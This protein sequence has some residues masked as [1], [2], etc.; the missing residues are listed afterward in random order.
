MSKLP[1]VSG[2]KC[3]RA[4]EKVGFYIVRRES[5]HITLVR[6]N[7][8]SQLTVPDHKEIRKGTLRGII[9]QAGLDVDEFRKL[10]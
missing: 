8:K 2:E 1:V 3:V 9:R 5:S 10:L 4:L 6:D 7:P